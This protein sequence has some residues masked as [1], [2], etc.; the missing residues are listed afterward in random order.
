MGLA[1]FRYPTRTALKEANSY[2]MQSGKTI[3]PIV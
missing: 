3:T 2:I 1:D